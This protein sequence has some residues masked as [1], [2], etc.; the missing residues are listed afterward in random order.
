M[1]KVNQSSRLYTSQEAGT[2]FLPG[3]VTVTTP[4]GPHSASTDMRDKVAPPTTKNTQQQFCAMEHPT[5][6][7]IQV[8]EPHIVWYNTPVNGKQLPIETSLLNNTTYYAA[9]LKDG[10]ESSDRLAIRVSLL[11]LLAPTTNNPV[12]VFFTE[13][14]PTIG[15]LQVL[16]SNIVWYD[17]AVA[18]SLLDFDTPLSHGKSYYAALIN[19]SC[20]S[21]ER[22][23]VSVEIKE[24]SDLKINK[25]VS[26]Q[27]PM[28]G[29]KIMLT[30]SVENNGSSNFKEV[31]IGEELESGF[32]YLSKNLTHGNYD[33]RNN[34]WT[35]DTLA[36]MEKAVLSLELETMANGQYGSTSFI[37]SS[38]PRDMDPQNNSAQINLEPSCIT[39][40]NEFTPN[41]DGDN[42]Y[43][44]IECIENFPDSNLQIF[45]RYGALVYQKKAYQNNW[46]GLANV[47]GVVGKGEPLPTGTYFYI[48]NLD[49]TSENTTGWLFLRK[50]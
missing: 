8:N 22:L 11:S 49:N 21:T 48:L 33:P 6:E 16:E 27:Q 36:P 5:L 38:V 47:N 45:N 29:E 42:D 7:S 19:N 1:S 10:K 9:Q 34:K 26:K 43:F 2:T 3:T 18:G 31:I 25:T 44:K 4:P 50:D 23:W 20:E 28:I 35:I 30:I 12:Q 46:R 13:D 32:K 15:D 24:T 17:Q 37:E 41:D 14:A 40:Y 39:I